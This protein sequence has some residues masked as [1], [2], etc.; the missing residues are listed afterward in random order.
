[1]KNFIKNKFHQSVNI[2]QGKEVHEPIHIQI[3]SSLK[4]F[5]GDLAGVFF[6]SLGLLSFL[7]LI[8]WSQG[9]LIDYWTS[10][11]KKG[12]G[13]GAYLIASF[14]VF[15]GILVLF[16]R[17]EKFPHLNLRRLLALEGFIFSII[18]ILA[19]FG[20]FSIEHA[21]MGAD[22]GIVGWGLAKII[23]RILPVPFST[24]LLFLFTIILSLMGLGVWSRLFN[25]IRPSTSDRGLIEPEL[26]KTEADKSAKE[27][28]KSK[29]IRASN[30][31]SVIQPQ[32]GIS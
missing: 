18:A 5:S 32:V 27:I 15:L 20:G 24:I 13:W 21:E 9:F 7:G 16:R 10:I 23:E 6:V 2:K 3:L 25:K 14:F 30:V 22:G 31:S 19:I 11:L 29:P 17:I 4:R 28:Q 8:G 26:S 1:M 12:F